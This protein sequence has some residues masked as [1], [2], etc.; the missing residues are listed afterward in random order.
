M[1][2]HAAAG[3]WGLIGGPVASGRAAHAAVR[4]PAAERD[5]AIDMLRGLAI[6]ILVVNHIHLDSVLEYVTATVLSAAEVLVAVS[7]VVAGMVFGRRWHTHGPRATTQ[8]LLK[9]ARTLYLAALAVVSLIGVTVL[10]PWIDTAALTASPDMQAGTNLYAY[11]GLLRTVAAV[12]TLEA[13]PW[14]L[15][16]LGLF[17]AL[18]VLTPALLAAL[19]RGWWLQAVALSWLLFA[20]GRAWPVDVLPMQSERPF[21]ILV[22]QSLFVHGIVVGYHR[23][24]IARRLR[25]WRRPLVRGLVALAS[26]VVL[27]RLQMAGLAPVGMPGLDAVDWQRWETRHFD[28]TSLDVGRV[29]A[30]ASVATAVYLGL[31][32]GGRV[33]ERALGWLLLP[34]GRN[35]FYVFIMHVFVCLAVALLPGMADGGLGLLG[36]AAVQAG[37]VALLWTMVRRRFLFSVVPR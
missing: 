5:V 26:L 12:L 3:P 37:C 13:G 10:L 33:A 4:G 28:K 7:G 11:E 14:Q 34:L 29:V 2:A 31:S 24:A 8:M 30:M 27:L 19:A 16:I 21:P 25:A 20:A 22:W 18:L 23:E 17:I 15:S 9:R 36:N 6:V 32:R 35:S 1:E